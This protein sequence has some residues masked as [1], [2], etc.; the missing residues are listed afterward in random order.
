MDFIKETANPKIVFVAAFMFFVIGHVLGDVY[1]S[2][3]ELEEL[4][5]SEDLVLDSLSEY[6]RR[7]IDR[8]SALERLE[9][10]RPLFLIKRCCGCGNRICS[11]FEYI[12]N[13]YIGLVRK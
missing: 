12:T 4:A 10:M 13:V 7:D 6:L 9:I 3:A 2:G 5:R 1:T 11:T 8:L